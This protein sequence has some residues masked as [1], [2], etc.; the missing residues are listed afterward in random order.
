MIPS[1]HA[2]DTDDPFGSKIPTY[3]AAMQPTPRLTNDTRI[4]PMARTYMSVLILLVCT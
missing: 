4:P 3:V 2:D 1:A